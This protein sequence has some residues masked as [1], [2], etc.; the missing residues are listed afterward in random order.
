MSS[1][2]TSGRNTSL[3]ISEMQSAPNA[4]PTS[5]MPAIGSAV[6]R[7]GRTLR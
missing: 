2:S 3:G 1:T 7:S 5:A 6:R 4:A